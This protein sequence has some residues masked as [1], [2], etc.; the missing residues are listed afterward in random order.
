MK[1][2][3]DGK[4]IVV[5]DAPGYSGKIINITAAHSRMTQDST[6]VC[7]TDGLYN[8]GYTDLI[9]NIVDGGDTSQGISY[10]RGIIG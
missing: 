5:E 8:I 1:V 10:L 6:T 3:L 2:F 4:Q 7:I 9:A